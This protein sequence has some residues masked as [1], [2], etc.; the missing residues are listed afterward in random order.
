MISVEASER[1]RGCIRKQGL[2]RDRVFVAMR[3]LGADRTNTRVPA[4]AASKKAITKPV[5]ASTCA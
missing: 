5:Q 1:F 3:A 4:C 2:D